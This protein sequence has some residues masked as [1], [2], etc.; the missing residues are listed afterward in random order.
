MNIIDSIVILIILMSGAIG[1]KK[2]LIR[3]FISF[4]GIALVFTL[5]YLLKDPV[6]EFLSL[7]L[8]FFEFTGIF[9]GVTILNVIIYQLISFF[10]IFAAFMSLYT[11]LVHISKIVEKIL[12]MTI[13]LAIPSKIGG[14]ILG[15][16]EGL[17]VSLIFI[18]ILSL[19]VL[20]F[21]SVRESKFR[22]YLY[23]N[24]PLI[25]NVTKNTNDAI[26]EIFTL[27][28]EFDEESDK[29]DFNLNCL[30]ILL[31]HKVIG[32]EYAKSLLDSGKLKIDKEK[33]NAII[34]KY[35]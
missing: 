21:N 12:K 26:D 8:P 4:A 13:I 10:F 17:L 28:D 14:F 3:S 18:I 32:K 20:N 6:A 7:K 35:E 1:M 25:G 22:N 24:S 5:S 19:P 16:F 33:A 27:K 29:E 31:K 34:D 15:L 23:N 30:D 2:G 9:S 11:F